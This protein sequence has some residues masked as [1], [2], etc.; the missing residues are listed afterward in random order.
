PDKNQR[1][2]RE[3]QGIPMPRRRLRSKRAM[4]EKGMR[5]TVVGAVV[6]ILAAIGAVVL[7]RYFAKRSDGSGEEEI[8]AN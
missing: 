7:I 4:E 3:P 8:S 1:L 2:R 6:I 5:V